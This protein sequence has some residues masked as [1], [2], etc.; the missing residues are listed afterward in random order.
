MCEH[1]RT[2]EDPGECECVNPPLP[3]CAWFVLLNGGC[4]GEGEIIEIPN[5]WR[6][7]RGILLLA[8][9]SRWG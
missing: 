1:V 8:G 6:K 3:L 2:P 9:D 7:L 5:I 4:P